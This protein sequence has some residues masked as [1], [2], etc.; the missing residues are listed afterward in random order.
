MRLKAESNSTSQKLRAPVSVTLVPKAFRY[1][2]CNY[3]A[4]HS[5]FVILF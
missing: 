4:N 1:Y 5:L 2:I 3:V